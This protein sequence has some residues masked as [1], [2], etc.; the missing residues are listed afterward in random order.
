M[1]RILAIAD[2]SC[3]GKCSLTLALPILSACGLE[4]SILPTMVL[5]THTGGFGKPVISDLTPAIGET[6]VHWKRE[7]ITFDAVL[8]GYLGSI[9]ACEAVSAA[10]ECL[11][12]GGLLI[13]DPAMGDN[14]RLYSGISPDFVEAIKNLCARADFVLPNLTEAQ[15]LAGEIF[16]NEET[17]FRL[18]PGKA[19][20]ITG[21][22]RD[23]SLV[24]FLY[25]E[26]HLHAFTHSQTPGHF[27]GTGD[28]FA[29]VFAGMLLRGNAPEAALQKAADFTRRAVE[30]SRGVED[31]RFGLLFEPLLTE[32]MNP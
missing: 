11:K 23:G 31:H 13:V 32:L 21:V 3:V 25:S 17:F 27:H 18:I 1:K 12:P 22:P 14:G 4:T 20:V 8:V 2:I 16:R 24:S 9:P 29:A 5:S 7:K 28:V 6:I 19:A 15:A 10:L 26:N 30:S